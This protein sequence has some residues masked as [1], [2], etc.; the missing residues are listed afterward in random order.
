MDLIESLH[1]LSL[2][3]PARSGFSSMA[4][5][6][7]TCISMLYSLYHSFMMSCD[8]QKVDNHSYGN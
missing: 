7:S 8:C 2:E 1:A 3:V 6:F 4:S 5:G